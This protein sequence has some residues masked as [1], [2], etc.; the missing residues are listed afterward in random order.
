MSGTLVELEAIFVVFQVL[1][2]L[3]HLEMI[4]FS[5]DSV[6]VNGIIH[7]DLKPKNVLLKTQKMADGVLLADFGLAK[8]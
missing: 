1:R 3:R 2:G 8:L 5:R 4:R 6:P 7:Y